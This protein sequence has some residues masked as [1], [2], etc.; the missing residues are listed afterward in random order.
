M[1]SSRAKAKRIL[2]E[3]K[4]LYPNPHH[5][6]NFENPFQLLVA[7]I[8]SAQCTD[9]KVNEVTSGLFRLYPAPNDFARERLDLIEEAV[10]PTGFFRNKAKAIKA[11]S[12]EI[13]ERFGGKVPGTLDELVTLP[14]IARKSANAILQHGF[15]KIEGIVV[16]THVIRV[17]KRLGWTENKDPVKIERDLMEL[18]DRSAWKW[19]PFYL[20]NHG[21]SI[22]RAQAPRCGECPVSVLCPSAM[23]EPP[24]RKKRKAKN[25][26][27]R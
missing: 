9:E 19:I 24:A 21:R 23:I 4:K 3:L 14:G 17:S 8:L 26:V 15:S 25:K 16:D 7:T 1:K 10:R 22:C 6:L 5:Y 12:I 27:S 20:K 18:F 11:S 2:T 13:I